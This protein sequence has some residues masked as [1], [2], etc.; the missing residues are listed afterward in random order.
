MRS[1][2]PG[3]SRASAAGAAATTLR[4]KAQTYGCSGA[5]YGC[6]VPTRPVASG[7][8]SVSERPYAAGPPV[9]EPVD[10]LIELTTRCSENPRPRAETS[11]TRY[12]T[13]PRSMR[14]AFTVL[15]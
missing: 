7:V 10:R 13:H 4:V 14:G 15:G 9:V 11:S 5:R 3:I 12:D 1:S 2:C 6:V 8:G